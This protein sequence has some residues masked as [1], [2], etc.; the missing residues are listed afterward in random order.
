MGSIR[1]PSMAWCERGTVLEDASI[2]DRNTK[3]YVEE[4]YQKWIHYKRGY[5][6]EGSSALSDPSPIQIR[7]IQP[8]RS[9]SSSTR[10]LKLNESRLIVSVHLSVYS[11][12]PKAD[13]TPRSECPSHHHTPPPTARPR[14]RHIRLKYN[15]HSRLLPALVTHAYRSI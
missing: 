3:V 8:D 12:Q 9:S 2:T 5:Q 10:T 4:I 6:Q 7:P 1:V 14:A 13:T 11:L 15:R